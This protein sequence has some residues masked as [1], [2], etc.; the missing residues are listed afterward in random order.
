MLF[1]HVPD[2][3]KEESKQPLDRITFVPLRLWFQSKDTYLY[4]VHPD[5][6]GVQ[7]TVGNTHSDKPPCLTL[8]KA[9][10]RCL[11]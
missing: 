3:E 5:T 4:T 11:S 6:S 8:F 9:P 2:E 7:C 1:A 10:F